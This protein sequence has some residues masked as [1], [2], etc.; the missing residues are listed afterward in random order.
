MLYREGK[1]FL[2]LCSVMYTDVCKGVLYV[3]S[4]IRFHDGACIRKQLAAV[5]ILWTVMTVTL[6]L[7]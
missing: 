1:K 5:L 7:H 2:M 3:Q 4:V 6:H